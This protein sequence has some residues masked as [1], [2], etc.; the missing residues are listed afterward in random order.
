MPVVNAPEINTTLEYTCDKWGVRIELQWPITVAAISHTGQES[1]TRASCVL[2]SDLITC[3]DY[4][5]K[6]NS[7]N[8]SEHGS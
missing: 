2:Y 4:V 1:T 8:I 6:V 5:N 7:N 3:S